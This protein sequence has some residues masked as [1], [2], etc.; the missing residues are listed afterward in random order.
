MKN[1][2][3]AHLTE[4][5]QVEKIKQWLA[6]N[7]APILIGVSIAVAG[8]FS[9]TFW[10]DYQQ[11]QAVSA[12]THY[13]SLVANPD[14]SEAFEQLKTNYGSSDYSKQATLLMAKQ[15]VKKQSYQQALDY[16]T[17]L[18]TDENEFTKHSAALKVVAIQ[19]QMGD[20]QQ[21]LDTLDT[22]DNEEFGSLYNQFRGDIYVALK[23]IKLAKQYYQIALSQITQNPELKSLIQIKLNDLN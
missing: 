10:G 23:N 15:A 5:E 18:L 16:L 13:L 9:F 19:L 3:E 1:F 22:Q 21:A 8:M 17:P 14:N 20:Y 4:Q 2:I 12:R 7:S 6:K 11:N